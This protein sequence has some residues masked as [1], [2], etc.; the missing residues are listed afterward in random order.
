[1]PLN[2]LQSNGQTQTTNNYLA[3]DVNSV[4]VEKLVLEGEK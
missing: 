2:I 4:K 1:M 3:Q